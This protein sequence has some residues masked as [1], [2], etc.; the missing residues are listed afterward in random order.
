MRRETLVS[1]SMH[2]PDSGKAPAISNVGLSHTRESVS[3]KLPRVSKVEVSSND[4]SV[5][6]LIL[7]CSFKLIAS[8]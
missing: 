2:V 6:G 5:Q 1:K 4:P 3:G 7:S 8:I